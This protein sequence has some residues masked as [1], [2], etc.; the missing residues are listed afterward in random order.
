MRLEQGLY[1]EVDA[2]IAGKHYPKPHGLFIGEPERLRPAA[3]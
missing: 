2:P 3:S 1:I